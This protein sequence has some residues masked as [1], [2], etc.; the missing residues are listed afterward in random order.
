ML[1]ELHILTAATTIEETKSKMVEL[2]VR[3]AKAENI[4]GMS[5]QDIQKKTALLQILNPVTK[6]HTATLVDAEFNVFYA[7]VMNF[8]N[9][10]SVGQGG[11]N[12]KTINEKD[13]SEQ[14]KNSENCED[15][16]GMGYDDCSGGLY[17]M[18]RQGSC[19]LCGQF[20]HFKNECPNKG[21]GK[22]GKANGGGMQ[23]KGKGKG[24][25]HQ[26]G[27]WT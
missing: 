17:A 3:I 14:G 4:S 21:K 27:C 9:N 10:A 7:K 15:M 8:T 1:L 18:Q 20:G 5:V 19:H 12:I 25:G 26:D 13:D 2:R 24:G 23:F 16:Y 11:G 6:Q 22:G